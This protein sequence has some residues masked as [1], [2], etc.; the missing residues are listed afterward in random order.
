MTNVP[1]QVYDYSEQE[2]MLSNIQIHK[3]IAKCKGKLPRQL[4]NYDTLCTYCNAGPETQQH[5]MM[6]CTGFDDLT[7]EANL[8]QLDENQ[9]LDFKKEA[10]I[11]T[12]ETFF[13]FYLVTW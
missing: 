4:Y 5:I 3:Q 1:T 13:I 12:I 2:T 10:D 6:E 7:G 8:N 9:N 11:I